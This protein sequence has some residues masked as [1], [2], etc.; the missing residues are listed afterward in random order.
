LQNA[1]GEGFVVSVEEITTLLPLTS[2]V[3]MGSLEFTWLHFQL[4]HNVYR[5]LSNELMIPK[6]L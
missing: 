2:R 1:L 3:R 6:K 5:T 4:L